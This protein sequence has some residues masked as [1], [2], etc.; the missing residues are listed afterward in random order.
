MTTNDTK[1]KHEVNKWNDKF[2]LI[3]DNVCLKKKVFTHQMY[4]HQLQL[5]CQMQLLCS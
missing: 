2:R 3:F 1:K 5:S 4:D